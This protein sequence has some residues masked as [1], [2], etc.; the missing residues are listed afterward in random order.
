[1]KKVMVAS[2]ILVLVASTFAMLF[3]TTYAAPRIK[4]GNSP[5]IKYRVNPVK[6]Q[7]ITNIEDGMPSDP[8]PFNVD[9]VD[10]E[11]TSN[12]G[13]GI[14]VAVLDTGLLSNYLFFF[15]PSMVD[16]KEEWGKG[17]THDVT[18]N[19]V[20]MQ[21]DFGP[22][23]DDR[24]F[25]T[26]DQWNPN[27]KK[28][29][30]K[31]GLG[32]GHGTHVTSII[33]GYHFIRETVDTFIRGVAPKVTIIPVLVLDDW[34]Y[35]NTT[36]REW[37]LEA[38]GTDEMVAEGIRYVGDLAR[39]HEVK[40][41]INLSLGGYEPTEMEKAAV[42]YAISQGCIV[43][44]SAGN[45]GYDGMGWPAAYPQVISV[46]S[47]GWTQ[48]YGGGDYSY[49]WWWNDVPEQLNTVN[50]VYDPYSE[51]TYRNNWQTYLS[52]FSS[53][54]NKALGQSQKDL[55][56]AAPGAAIRGPYKPYGLAQW[57]Y[58]AVWGTSQAA[59]H[60]CGVGALLLQVPAYQ[61]LMQA[62]MEIIL[63]KAASRIPMPA[64]GAY[65]SDIFSDFATVYYHWTAHD[66]GSGFLT[67]DEAM[68]SALAYV[69]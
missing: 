56:L 12:D 68:Q 27:P 47:A 19:P 9:M 28:N 54:P 65:V 5:R 66:A 67:T 13:D 55:D 17:F 26:H 2:I 50:Y 29:P 4:I 61:N 16:I 21:L 43:V 36:D 38:G 37:Y 15:P 59:P 34:L 63:S 33:T 51:I 52:D 60:V 46:A 69:K 20:T 7:E 53:R 40:I 58:Y 57:N 64:D 8:I 18:Y 22:L 24:G 48:E 39:D 10:A 30:F 44:A 32:S 3:Q 49:Y 1:M 42:D 35:F 31:T 45:E 62:D 23:R 41:I 11:T 6:V 25:I 14:Y